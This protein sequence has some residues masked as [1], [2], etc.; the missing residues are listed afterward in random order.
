MVQD[1]EWIHDLKEELSCSTEI[2]TEKLCKKVT[3]V[4]MQVFLSSLYYS[5]ESYSPIHIVTVN[6]GCSSDYGYKHDICWSV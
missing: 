4:I 2:L 3:F 5:S 1:L 6:T